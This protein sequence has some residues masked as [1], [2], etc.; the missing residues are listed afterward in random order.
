[1]PYPANALQYDQLLAVRTRH[2]YKVQHG[3]LLLHCRSRCAIGQS[4]AYNVLKH[5][6]RNLQ[7]ETFFC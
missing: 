3:L 5:Q 6:E 4:V 2:K 7:S 1:M